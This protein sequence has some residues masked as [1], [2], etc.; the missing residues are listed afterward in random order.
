MDKKPH[1]NAKAINSDIEQQLNDVIRAKQQVSLGDEAQ[2]SQRVKDK[3]SIKFKGSKN[4]IE[5]ALSLNKSM[6]DR[7]M[8]RTA[9]NQR[10]ILTRIEK[11]WGSKNLSFS[12]ITLEF[13]KG[14][15]AYLIKDT[16]KINTVNSH[17]AAIRG[18]LYKA[19]NEK[20]PL[21]TREKN[22]FNQYK[23]KYTPTQ[24]E[25]L[26]EAEIALLRDAPLNPETDQSIINVRNYYLFSFN[27]A[28]IRVSDLM[29]LKVK[30]I[31]SGR[32]HYEMGK[33][34]HFKS[35]KLNA[36]SCDIINHYVKAD[37]KQEDYL[38]P[39]LSNEIH[40]DDADI[41]RKHL[42]SKTARINQLLKKL[43]TAAKLP[44]RLHFHSS[45]HSFSNMARKKNADLYSIS[46]ALGHKSLKV[47]EMYLSSF[48]EEALDETMEMIFKK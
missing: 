1:S 38:F 19:M 48:D 5:Y 6:M 14:Y 22:P 16:V 40:F 18:I 32:L 45:R 15:E 46:K 30:N 21:L 10:S 39:I 43:A 44:K 29:Q 26:S 20:E 25:T 9:K 23:L 31:A 7:N 47:T 8:V 13:L 35:I 11:Y 37:A 36:E 17:M 33:T 24:K 41:L 12:E 4:F 27:N 28:G 3:A 2:T 42:E 34:G